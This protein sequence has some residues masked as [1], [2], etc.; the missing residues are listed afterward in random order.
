MNPETLKAAQQHLLKCDEI[1]ARVVREVGAPQ[2]HRESDAWRALTSSIIG[3]QV[4]VHATRAIRGRFAAAQEGRDF[5]TPQWTATA[6]D[7]TFRN[8]RHLHLVGSR[9]RRH[10]ATAFRSGAPP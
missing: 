7:E 2:L 3:Q 8:S 6:D 9:F 10:R 4:S 5:P 1:L